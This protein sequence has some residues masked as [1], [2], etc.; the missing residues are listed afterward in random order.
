MILTITWWCLIPT[1]SKTWKQNGQFSSTT[2]FPWGCNNLIC[3]PILICIL[4]LSILILSRLWLHKSHQ[5][6]NLNPPAWLASF[7]WCSA[8]I[9]CLWS[10]TKSLNLTLH[11]PQNKFWLNPF[12][13]F[14]LK[15]L[16]WLK[17]WL[18]FKWYEKKSAVKSCSQT[19]QYTFCFGLIS[20][21][22]LL[23]DLLWKKINLDLTIIHNR[24]NSL[25]YQKVKVKFS[26]CIGFEIAQRAK[27]SI[28]WS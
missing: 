27:I 19:G 26:N 7:D 17:W 2:S 9:K 3:F 22:R 4:N 15:W 6:S 18:P 10:C 12:D 24:T 23:C 13:S 11:S 1:W 21:S 25:D 16:N 20:W 28:I 5:K 14:L 8:P